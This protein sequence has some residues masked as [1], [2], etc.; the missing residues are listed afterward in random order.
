MQFNLY[1][2]P[3]HAWLKVPISLL[4]ELSI[5][6]QISAYSYQKGN[7]AYLEE[8]CDLSAFMEAMEKANKP[9]TFKEHICRNRSSKIRSYN[10]YKALICL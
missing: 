9:V 6:D 10:Q 7:F 8:D 1:S 2:D 3:G 5:A 4:N